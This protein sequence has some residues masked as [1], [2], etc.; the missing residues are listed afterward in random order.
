MKN[1]NLFFNQAGIDAN[2]IVF[3][4]LNLAKK[5]IVINL[6]E[7]DKLEIFEYLKIN[8]SEPTK[9]ELPQKNDIFDLYDNE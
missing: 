9:I 3:F 4:K 7:N 5:Q 8:L 1:F 6:K 2:L